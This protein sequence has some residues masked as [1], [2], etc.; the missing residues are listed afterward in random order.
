MKNSKTNYINTQDELI[1]E[2]IKTLRTNLTFNFNNQNSTILMVTSSLKN[3]GKTFIS[4]NIAASL[5]EAKYKVLIIDSDL[6]KARMHKY[7]S[8][9]NN[10]GLSN[11]ISGHIN[12]KDAITNTNIQNLDLLTS[13]DIPP[14]PSELLE[15]EEFEQLLEILEKMYDYIIIDTPPILPVTDALI[16]GGLVDL[17]ILVINSKHTHKDS[18]IEA[19]Q[20]LDHLNIKIFGAVLNQVKGSNNHLYY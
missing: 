10:H 16:V 13:G 15:S 9:P 3:E 6:R 8:V 2:Q 5:A 1:K 4:R 14:N 17:T 20:R 12:I 18:V 7:F 11:V 19:K